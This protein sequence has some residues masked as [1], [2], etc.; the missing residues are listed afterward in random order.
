M[1]PAAGTDRQ[2]SS[3]TPP[4]ATR[5]AVEVKSY[6]DRAEFDELTAARRPLPQPMLGFAFDGVKFGTF[7]EYLASVIARPGP[8][9][10]SGLAVMPE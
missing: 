1:F 9:G 2:P 3:A 8:G 10:R 6:L 4:A 7:C 5:V